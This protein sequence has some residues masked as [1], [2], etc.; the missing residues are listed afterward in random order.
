VRLV[1]ALDDVRRQVFNEK[2]LRRVHDLHSLT[3][4]DVRHMARLMSLVSYPAGSTI[5]RGGSEVGQLHVVH[6]GTVRAVGTS[7][8]PDGEPLVAGAVFGEASLLRHESV[9]STLVAVDEVTCMVVSR[10]AIQRHLG[11][12]LA[13]V[14]HGL[15]V[16]AR[17]CHGGYP[18]LDTLEREGVLGAGA[19]GSVA[20][21][22]HASRG[23]TY[24]LKSMSKAK[25]WSHGQ[26]SHVLDEVSVLSELRHPFIVSLK[27]VYADATHVHLLLEYLKGG[28][29][30]TV[31]RAAPNGAFP[32][33]R[34]Q[35]YAAMVVLAFEYLHQL[36]IAYRDLKPE[37]LLFDAEGY[38]KLVDFGFAKRVERRTW[39]LCGTPE[40][41]APEIILHS[42]HDTSVDWWTLGVLIYEVLVGYP[43]FEGAEP[44]ALYTHIV[45]GKMRY[46][47]TMGSKASNV[48]S[49]LLSAD[50]IQRL[51]ASKDGADEVK[52]HPFFR[53]VAWHSL[54]HKKI[55]APHKPELAAATMANDNPHGAAAKKPG[56]TFPPG[57]FDSFDQIAVQHGCH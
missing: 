1:G 54:L 55:E 29:L 39:T 38:L 8:T 47:K 56:N 6:C 26:V 3:A 57:A 18:P 4:P 41:L 14:E 35:F 34:C 50:P 17:P 45:Q 25:L 53:K 15:P 22:H 43:P 10:E 46:P 28:E 31:L 13:L 7:G 2:A 16:H 32:E 33:R 42:G 44:L 49:K 11:P 5:A 37:N 48:I 40:Y 51:G 23:S 52:R 19:F 9:P 20:L 21:V 12:I 30:V 24:A 27:A 36:R